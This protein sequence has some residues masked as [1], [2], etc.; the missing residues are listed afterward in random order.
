MHLIQKE[1]VMKNMTWSWRSARAIA[2]ILLAVVIGSVPTAVASDS[3]PRVFPPDAAVFGMTYGDLSAAWWQYIVSIPAST[4]PL[5]D[6][7]GCGP[8]QSSGPILFLAGSFVGPV[9][10]TCTVPSG[11][12]ILIPIINVE[13]STLEEAPFHGSNE[14]ELRS[15]AATFGDAIGV[16]TLAA[17]IDGMKVK[18]LGSFRAQ[19]PVF[20]FTLLYG[21]VLGAK[22]GTGFSASDGYW[23]MLKPLSPGQHVIHFEGACVSGSPCDGFSQNVNYNL[24]VTE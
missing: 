20:G 24:T 22:P 6:V 11:K 16:N 4:N 5:N 23:L 14:A 10:R 1:R 7:T 2:L 15:C 18:D 17:T 12:V 21:N 3:N 13:C 19:S 9:T 8:Q